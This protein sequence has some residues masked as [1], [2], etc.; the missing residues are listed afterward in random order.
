MTNPIYSTNLRN[1]GKTVDRMRGNPVF[2]DPSIE[3]TF[4]Q[5]Y[6]PSAQRNFPLIYAAFHNTRDLEPE[7]F[8]RFV[9]RKRKQLDGLFNQH[10]IVS[11]PLP[12]D[13]DETF[14]LAYAQSQRIHDFERAYHQEEDLYFARNHLVVDDNVR[15]AC[16]NAGI[17]PELDSSL[18][19][20]LTRELLENLD[21]S[22]GFLAN[23]QPTMQGYSPSIPS[24][25]QY[26]IFRNWAQEND[27]EVWQSFDNFGELV[28]HQEGYKI[29]CSLGEEPSLQPTDLLFESSFPGVVRIAEKKVL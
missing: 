12:N 10:G 19:L 17:C 13:F 1:L 7:G 8:C 16:A 28:R 20:V 3:L 2:N 21:G 24:Y 27:P 29:A 11:F 6:D 25:E 9:S 26:S 18:R 23:L 15:Q 4:E 5:D 22:N 14:T